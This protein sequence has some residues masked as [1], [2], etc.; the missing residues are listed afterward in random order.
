MHGNYHERMTAPAW[1]RR[2][3]AG[4]ASL[5]ALFFL[6]VCLT[7]VLFAP[8]PSHAVKSR[9]RT[10]ITHSEAVS[11]ADTPSP[12]GSAGVQ[13]APVGP[14]DPL[15]G[16]VRVSRTLEASV[17]IADAM[18]AVNYTI[19]GKMKVEGTLQAKTLRYGGCCVCL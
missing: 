5:P 17:L 15:L 8:S 4:G 13:T 1:W 6:W 19:Q 16:H 7:V 10:R 2:G 9:T 11:V 12:A 3:C 18:F 14:L